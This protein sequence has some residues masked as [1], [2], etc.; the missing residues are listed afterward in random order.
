[1]FHKACV[2]VVISVL[3]FGQLI[4]AAD[5]P[6][7]SNFIQCL[8]RPCALARCLDGYSCKDDY[9]GGC[10]AKCVP[11]TG[12][13]EGK[14]S[15]AN[16]S[17]SSNSIKCPAGVKTVECET[18]P[19]L[20]ALCP[21]NTVC[22]A[23][24]CGECKPNCVPIPK[25]T[26]RP[27][28]STCPDGSTP[29][30]C[31]VDPCRGKNCS[32][33][34]TCESNYCGG[35]KATCVSKQPTKTAKPCPCPRDYRPV[36]GKDNKTYSNKCE[37]AC[38]KVDIAYNGSCKGTDTSC[39]CI[40]VYAQV[41]GEDG[42]TYSNECKAACATTSVAY[43]GTC[44]PTTKPNPSPGLTFQ[45]SYVYIECV[46]PLSYRPVCGVNGRTYGNPCDA[47]CAKVDVA[48]GGPCQ[49]STTKP[50]APKSTTKPP[51]PKSTTKPPAPKGNCICPLQYQPVCGEDGKTYGNACSAGCAGVRVK[52]QGECAKP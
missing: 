48:Y 11:L 2:G 47:G 17:T 46:C 10:N 52:A 1:M 3:A 21:V 12:N 4:A 8:A 43:N 30:Q 7:G 9:C 26:P 41:C 25:A 49:Q 16:N 18:N 20:A 14:P 37:A 39:N 50:P 36:C 27:K 33:S 19:C 45:L 32:A 35:C 22:Q 40:E 28:Q 23:D 24:N 13:S 51:P 5:C 29:V 15:A 38:Q 31:L 44:K 6:D 34:Q 42:I